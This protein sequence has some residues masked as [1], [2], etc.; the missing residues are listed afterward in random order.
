M[1]L[2]QGESR[3]SGARYYTVK[4]I[5][6]WWVPGSLSDTNTTWRDMMEWCV[7]TYG[8]SANMGVWEPGAKWYAN[9]AKFWFREKDDLA[10]FI[11]RWGK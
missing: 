1:E 2:E 4:P 5:F 3:V 11:L 7:S 10:Y 8:P 6:E 9:N